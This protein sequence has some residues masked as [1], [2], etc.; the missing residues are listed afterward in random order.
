MF[1]FCFKSLRLQGK[2]KRKCQ[3]WPHHQFLQNLNVEK[4]EVERPN[5]RS[6]KDRIG[7]ALPRKGWV[8]R[9]LRGD[10]QRGTGDSETSQAEPVTEG[11]VKCSNASVAQKSLEFIPLIISESLPVWHGLIKILHIKISR[12]V[13]KHRGSPQG[14]IT[15][16]LK[17]LCLMKTSTYVSNKLQHLHLIH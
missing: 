17:W 1:F 3:Q 5:L 9:L 11:A 2:G 4:T 16:V 14:E 10:F 13:T 7:S 15:A 6:G 12:L 8:S